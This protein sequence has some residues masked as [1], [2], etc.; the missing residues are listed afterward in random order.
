M[1]YFNCLGNM[2]TNNARCTREI[3][4][5]IAMEKNINQQEY[6]FHQETGLQ[7][8]KVRCEVHIWSIA[9]VWCWNVDTSQSRSEI[10]GKFW[11]V[12]LKKDGEGSWTDREEYS[13]II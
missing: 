3:K 6:S 10:P 12:L 4:S 7:F 8:K 2:V 9:F 13:S 1:E 11:N 5:R